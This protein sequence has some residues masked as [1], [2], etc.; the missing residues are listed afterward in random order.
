MACKSHE[1]GKVHCHSKSG[2]YP[3]G[4]IISCFGNSNFLVPKKLII[5]FF[6]AGTWKRGSSV[7]G[8]LFTKR[9]LSRLSLPGG[10]WIVCSGSHSCKPWWG[11]HWLSAW[12]TQECQQWC[13]FTSIMKSL[14]KIYRRVGRLYLL[15]TTFYRLFV[16]A[17][18]L[19]LV[20]LHWAQQDKMSMI[21][22]SLICTRMMPLQVCRCL[23]NFNWQN[24]WPDL[25]C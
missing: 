4:I 25:L 16:M 14:K 1:L 13:K 3:Q 10:R 9:H 21:F 23:Q 6:F 5:A 2:C 18:P 17:G 15:R 7:N 8:Y 20:W 19:A 22:S 24:Y 11:Y 12:S